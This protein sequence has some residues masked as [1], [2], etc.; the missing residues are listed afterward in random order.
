MILKSL[1]ASTH[2]IL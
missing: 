2:T 1:L